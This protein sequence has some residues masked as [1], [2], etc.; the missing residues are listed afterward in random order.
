MIILMLSED[1]YSEFYSICL[2]RELAGEVKKA[3]TQIVEASPAIS[4]HLII[5][6]TIDL[7]S[8]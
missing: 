6:K 2:D 7:S 1:D 5:P 8:A 4:K 3:I